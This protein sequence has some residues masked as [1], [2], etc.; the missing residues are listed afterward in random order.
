MR[1]IFCPRGL[2]RWQYL[3]YVNEFSSEIS[4]EARANKCIT[5]GGEFDSISFVKLSPVGTR[6]CN[7][8]EVTVSVPLACFSVLLD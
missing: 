6:L 5:A 2:K 3:L 7:Q 1:R 8:Y 4:N